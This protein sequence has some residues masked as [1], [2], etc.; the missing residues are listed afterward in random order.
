MARANFLWG[1][2]CIHGEL[3]KLGIII[4]QAIVSRY[5]PVCTEAIGGRNGGPSAETTLARLFAVGP[6]KGTIGLTT[7]GPGRTMSVRPELAFIWPTTKILTKQL[8]HETPCSA[9]A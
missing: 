9:A 6:S 3:L 4:S 2:P 1:T 5:M 8:G 7:S